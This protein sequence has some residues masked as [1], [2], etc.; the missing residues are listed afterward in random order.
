M[1]ART[2]Q[3]VVL[4]ILS[5]LLLLTGCTTATK[6][7]ETSETKAVDMSW[8]FHDIVDVNFVKPLVT[9]PQPKDVMLVDSRPKK[10]KF[11]KGYIPTAI[12]IPD[13]QFDKMANLLPENKDAL[14]IFYC[15][16]PT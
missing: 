16:G 14:L 8:K 3:S 6:T 10:G 13:S 15:Q 12:N 11:D 1:K 7:A 5:V 2:L 4:A 9:M